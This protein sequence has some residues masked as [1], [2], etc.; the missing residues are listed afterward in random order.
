M[1]DAMSILKGLT[2]R[3]FNLILNAVS[4]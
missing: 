3:F 2:K 4:F 1:T